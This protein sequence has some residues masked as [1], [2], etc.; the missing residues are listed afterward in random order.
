MLT[1]T[2]TGSAFNVELGNNG[3]FIKRDKTL[4]L[5]DCGSSTFSKLQKNDIF[6]DV[7]KIYVLMTHLHPDHAGSLGDL[8]LYGYY[9]LG[10]FAESNVTIIAPSDL[11]V[12]SFLRSTGVV[13]EFYTHIPL[14]TTYQIQD[15]TMPIGIESV[16][17]TH[18]PFL[19]CYGYVL[20]LG[21]ECVY[22]SGDANMIPEDILSRLKENEF[23]HFYQDTCGAEYPGNVHLPLSDLKEL[24]PEPLRHKVSCMHL[25]EV[26]S[27]EEAERL[28]FNVVSSGLQYM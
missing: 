4:F 25:D 7:E 12:C 9:S 26:F 21:D 6:K 3:V 8:V 28:G 15:E 24:I 19:N 5:I 18:V 2:G 20:T 16:H 13:S 17:V 1:F 22:Y 27:R 11:E 10:A 23:T 14:D